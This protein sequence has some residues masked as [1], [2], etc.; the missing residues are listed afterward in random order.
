MAG[1]TDLLTKLAEKGD[2]NVIL[3]V[4]SGAVFHET[5]PADCID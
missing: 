2:K 1:I 4:P 3:A 5:I